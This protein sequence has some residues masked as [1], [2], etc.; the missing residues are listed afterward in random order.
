MEG[1]SAAVTLNSK[2][3]GVGMCDRGERMEGGGDGDSMAIKGAARDG[4]GAGKDTS[5]A[6]G[7]EARTSPTPCEGGSGSVEALGPT[8]LTWQQH[9]AKVLM[10][11]AR[12][13]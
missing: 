12:A 3:Q 8:L 9:G 4:K 10:N 13:I 5:R 2:A 6:G 11:K 7:W 1:G